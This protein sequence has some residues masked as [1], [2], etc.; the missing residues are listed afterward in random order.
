M[1]LQLVLMVM[2]I[3]F[4]VLARLERVRVAEDGV[5]E[6]SVGPD[7]LSSPDGIVFTVSLLFAVVIL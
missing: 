4:K 5:G 7:A 6:H 1:V 3:C 2:V